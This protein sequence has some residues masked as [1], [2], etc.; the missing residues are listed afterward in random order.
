MTDLSAFGDAGFNPKQYI[1]AA[2]A[3]RTG[4][5]PL[6]RC[7][8]RLCGTAAAIR[9]RRRAACIATGLAPRRL[10]PRRPRRLNRR[11]P[12]LATAR[13]SLLLPPRPCPSFLAELEMKLHLSAEDVGLYLQD[14]STRAQQRI[15][16]ATKELLRIQV[17]AGAGG[18]GEVLVASDETRETGGRAG[19]LGAAEQSLAPHPPLPAGQPHVHTRRRCTAPQDDVAALRGSAAA[20]LAQLEA[21]GSG[22]AAGVVGQLAELDRVKGRMEEASSTLKVGA[23]TA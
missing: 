21:A 2:C 18:C 12:L 15:P 11:H 4:D 9:G 1:N 3:A 16:A 23:C 6:E 5:E 22:Q 13:A 10:A 8:G 14:H 17:G 20:A 19:Q 7:A